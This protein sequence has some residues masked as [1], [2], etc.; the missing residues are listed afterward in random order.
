MDSVVF[1]RSGKAL[2]G[3][4][5][6]HALARALGPHHPDG[7]RETIDERL[8]RRWA[9]GERDIPGWVDA[10]LAPMLEREAGRHRVL[11]AELTVLAGTVREGAPETSDAPSSLPPGS[12]M[13]AK[14]RL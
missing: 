3:S 11:A 1:S 10:A 7:P 6:T 9:A 12:A 13:P 14:L 8:V 2:L 5:W 4:G